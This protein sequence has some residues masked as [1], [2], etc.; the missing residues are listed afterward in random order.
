MPW[1]DIGTPSAKQLLW[2]IRT[3]AEADPNCPYHVRA[4]IQQRIPVPL[5]NAGLQ[6]NGVPYEDLTNPTAYEEVEAIH[7]DAVTA[8]ASAR[9]MARLL[10]L[11][12]KTELENF[13]SGT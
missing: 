9:T 8:S 1:P 10:W 11:S 13:P 7:Q 5:C 4:L 3:L 2:S 6:K 12:I